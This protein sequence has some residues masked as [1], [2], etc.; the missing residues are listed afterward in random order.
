[1]RSLANVRLLWM[2]LPNSRVEI[3]YLLNDYAATDISAYIGI[4]QSE[5]IKFSVYTPNYSVA[6]DYCFWMIIS[7]N[8]S[9]I[10]AAK[11][12]KN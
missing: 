3:I 5:L 2:D 7:H 1:M 11:F 10:A 8:L 12:Q 6:R 4:Y 9:D